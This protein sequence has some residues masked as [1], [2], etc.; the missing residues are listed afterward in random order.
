MGAE[1]TKDNQGFEHLVLTHGYSN[2]EHNIIENPDAYINMSIL[3]F[4][5]NDDVIITKKVLSKID[6]KIYIMK[7]IKIN[8]TQE[9]EDEKI[10]SEEDKNNLIKI[11]PILK[12]NECQNIIKNIKYFI[13]D[14]YLYII[15]E[16]INNGDLQSYIKTL[17]EIKE[18]FNQKTDEVTLWYIFLQCAKAL[19]YLHNK[20][21]IHRNIRLEN[22][23][24]TDDKVIKIGNFRNAILLK[25]VDNPFFIDVGED[26][27]L[28]KV[29][30]GVLYR[31]PE[32][33]YN[34]SYGKKTD[35]YS[36]GVV[37][38]KLCYYDFP[39]GKQYKNEINYKSNDC[40]EKMAEIITKMLSEEKTRPNADELYDLI[41]N[42]Y[43]K[44]FNKNSSIEAV[45]R[46]LISY[47]KTSMY[48]SEKKNNYLNE[49]R[50][51]FSFNYIKC[52][53]NFK[54]NNDKKNYGL[55][56][57]NIR[58]LINNI[59]NSINN[60]QE[61]NPLLVLNILLEELTKETNST[62]KRSSLKIQPLKFNA[63]KPQTYNDFKKD[64]SDNYKSIFS[65]YFYGYLKIKRICNHKELYSYCAIPYL[66]IQ[67]DRCYSDKDNS[68]YEYVPE[69]IKWFNL[70][71]NH[72][73]QLTEK[74]SKEY[75]IICNCC[76]SKFREFRQMD[77]NDYQKYLIIAINRGEKY[78]NKSNVKYCLDINW[79]NGLI[80]ELIGIV[81]RIS[82]GKEEYFISI[83][84]DFSDR[85]KW[86][87]YNKGS[88]VEI[89]DPNEH[90]DGDIIMLC[91]SIIEN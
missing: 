15:N 38:H 64:F 80:Y 47:K 3:G 52:M 5:D 79:P 22:I 29:I 26:E 57:N 54:S 40:P 41:L 10:L 39:N 4:G 72:C 61:I 55:Y 70:Y 32:M 25:N 37:F 44:L 42:E 36:L 6:N 69:L 50:T 17:K 12:D 66:E 45:L 81:K 11:L 62:N 2:N 49:E 90:T 74:L 88:N 7:Q 9:N 46:C 87:V 1:L 56:L 23:Y 68:K 65:E 18:G 73:K 58:N 35:I 20:Y 30:G 91:Y 34:L 27:R 28:N 83:N 59:N 51:P 43:V 75:N 8:K 85:R 60:D 84:L 71:M 13:K 86:V 21:I 63:S 31:S 76:N 48:M 33:L 24:I 82:D 14:N 77:I 89:N 19:K 16:F 67:L 53:E 78:I